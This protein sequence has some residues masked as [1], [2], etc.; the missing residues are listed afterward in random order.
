VFEPGGRAAAARGRTKAAL[1]LDLVVRPSVGA[2]LGHVRAWGLSPLPPPSTTDRSELNLC[3]LYDRST[4]VK[5][6]F[7]DWIRLTEVTFLLLALP[8]AD[9]MY[10]GQWK[11]LVFL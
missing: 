9:I 6:T 7:V 10:F 1:V 5:L 8:L 4:E 2:G 11:K 3:W